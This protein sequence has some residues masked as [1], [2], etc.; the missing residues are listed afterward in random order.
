[1]RQIG[2]P[3]SCQNSVNLKTGEGFWYE[4]IDYA[5]NQNRPESGSRTPRDHDSL[6]RYA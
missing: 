1:M 5:I 4:I 2:L 6:T 3:S